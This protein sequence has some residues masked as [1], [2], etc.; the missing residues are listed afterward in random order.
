[1]RHVKNATYQLD[2][3][4][5]LDG[6]YSTHVPL[7]V[8]QVLEVGLGVH[9]QAVGM[10]MH[11]NAYECMRMHANAC[12]CMRMHTNASAYTSECVCE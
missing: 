10:K 4:D 8:I 7:H 5:G 1:M 12:E 11:A 6:L 3:L 9:Q 2:G